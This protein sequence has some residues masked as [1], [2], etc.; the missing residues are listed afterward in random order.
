MELIEM[1][2]KNGER[3]FYDFKLDGDKRDISISIIK[4][5]KYIK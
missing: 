5:R 1:T 4:S 3:K 2:F